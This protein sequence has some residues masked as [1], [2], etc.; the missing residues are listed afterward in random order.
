MI[1]CRV[2]QLKP[3]RQ[4]AI[5]KVSRCVCSSVGLMSCLPFKTLTKY[6][7]SA[8]DACM[9]AAAWCERRRNVQKYLKISTKTN[10]KMTKN[11]NAFELNSAH[12]YDDD[13]DD[14]RQTLPQIAIN[15]NIHILVLLQTLLCCPAE[16]LPH[17][18][19]N[20]SILECASSHYFKTFSKIISSIVQMRL[21]EHQ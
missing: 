1:L 14:N 3:E 9:C 4:N 19:C 15:N 13:D 17:S 6:W 7:G 11:S 10:K 21:D 16:A 2:S 5:F 18:R 12:M 8:D 20:G